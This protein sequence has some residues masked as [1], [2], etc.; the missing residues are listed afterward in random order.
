MKELDEIAQMARDRGQLAAATSAIM[1][2]AKIAGLI[3]DKQQAKTEV[4]QAPNEDE[5]RRAVLEHV[6]AQRNSSQALP[7]HED[8]STKH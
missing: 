1:G 6:L 2:K 3:I 5:L 8:D 7:K 4:T